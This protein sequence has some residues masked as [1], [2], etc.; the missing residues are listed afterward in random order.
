M[1]PRVIVSGKVNPRGGGAVA[2]AS[3]N[4]A[5]L[6]GRGGPEARRAIHGQ[7]EA[8]V[9]RGGGPNRL[10]LKNHRMSCGLE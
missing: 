2:K 7:A 3:P 5:K 10:V 6:V 1:S 8:P 4:W 9:T